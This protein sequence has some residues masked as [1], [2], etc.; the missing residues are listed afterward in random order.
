M[1]SKEVLLEMVTFVTAT[2]GNPQGYTNLPEIIQSNSQEIAEV[3]CVVGSEKQI[4]TCKRQATAIGAVY[5]PS[6]NAVYYNA[7]V[8][9]VTSNPIHASYIVHELVHWR[10]GEVKYLNCEQLKQRELE[11]YQ[12]QDKYLTSLGIGIQFA[13]KFEERY[14]CK[15]DESR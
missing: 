3:I 5:V 4:E 14:V 7:F 12:I 8:L 1:F 10:Q 6:K 9:K 15:K 2:M 11:A 13:G